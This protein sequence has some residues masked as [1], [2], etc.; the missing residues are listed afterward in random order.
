MAANFKPSTVFSLSLGFMG[1][2]LGTWLLA[3]QQPKPSAYAK[4]RQAKQQ[5]AQIWQDQNKSVHTLALAKKTIELQEALIDTMRQDLEQL[6]EQLQSQAQQENRLEA[7]LK[8]LK[9]TYG[10]M[11]YQTA[12]KHQRLRRLAF[13]F[14]AQSI[15]EGYRRLRY[16]QQYA[17]ARRQQAQKLQRTKSKIAQKRQ[18]SQALYAQQQ[19]LLQ[20]KLYALDTLKMLQQEQANLQKYLLSQAQQLK[21]DLVLQNQQIAKLQKLQQDRPQ[22]NRPLNRPSAQPKPK[23]PS[24]KSHYRTGKG[25][26]RQKGKLP[27]PLSW[28]VLVSKFG[29]QKH[30]VLKDIYLDN[31][32]IT[33]QSSPNAPVKAVFAGEVSTI[34]EIPGISGKV[35]MLKHGDYLTVYVGLQKLRVS[36]GDWV[37]AGETIAQL[38]QDPEKGY[39]LEFQIWHKNKKLDPSHWLSS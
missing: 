15:N 25:F 27:R 11:I 32:G 37:A 1:L 7:E 31:A 14:S 30:P 17:E 8:N 24:D 22:T 38:A 16:L 13:V 19:H 26:A 28:S 12:K 34:A 33:L 39:R 10:E 3:Q 23:A 2:I 20:E 18:Q 4:I 9:K 36:N 35:L 5:L 29:K 6:G 21:K